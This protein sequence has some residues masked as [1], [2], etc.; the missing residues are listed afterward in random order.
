MGS[1]AS[2][3]PA[4]SPLPALLA[5]G[6]P[7]VSQLQ[8][9]S[10][11]LILPTPSGQL[12]ASSQALI[13]PTLTCGRRRRRPAPST[14]GT[15]PGTWHSRG[16]CCLWGSRRAKG[17]V[18]LQNGPHDS[19]SH[20]HLAAGAGGSGI[21]RSS[22]WSRLP[23]KHATPCAKATMPTCPCTACRCH[24]TVSQ[25]HRHPATTPITISRGGAP[26]PPPTHPPA[27][28]R[29]TLKGDTMPQRW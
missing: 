15:R 17:W 1:P 3:G 18:A 9:S 7:P 25:H 26:P 2:R 29:A 14:L 28:S 21:S 13:L 11:A 24:C 6:R 8:A 22:R 23:C 27:A 16:R 19:Y 12:Q 5:S 10:Q 20:M 4:C